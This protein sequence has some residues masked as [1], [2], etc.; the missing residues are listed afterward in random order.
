MFG[1]CISFFLVVVSLIY[2]FALWIGYERVLTL[3]LSILWFLKMFF[4]FEKQVKLWKMSCCF[5]CFFALIFFLNPSGFL[6]MLYPS[7]VNLLL[8]AIFGISMKGEAMIT[9]FARLEHSLKKYAD[10]NQQEVQYTRFLNKVWMGVFALNASVLLILAIAHLKTLW[11]FYSG[12]FGYVLIGIVLF[13]ERIFRK[14]I[15]KGYFQWKQ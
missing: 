6:T 12:V 4:E 14:T 2:P 11:V 9:R 7:F 3:I 5:G 13:G 8:L 1:K 10:L 15:Q